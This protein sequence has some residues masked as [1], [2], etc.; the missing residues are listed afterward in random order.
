MI[1]GL[2]GVDHA[3][4]G[5]RDLEGARTAFQ[6]LGFTITPRG[7]HIG[8]GTAN[9]CVMFQEDYLELLGILDSNQFTNNLDRF[10]AK[11]EGLLGLAFASRD[12]T[13]LRESL[14]DQ[15]IP[16]DGPKDLKRILELPGGEAL[17]AFSLLYPSPGTTPGLSAFVCQHLTRDLVWQPHWTKHLNGAVGLHELVTVVDDPGGLALDYARLFG[18]DQVAVSDGLVRVQAG[19]CQLI[20]VLP[21]GLT[22]LYPADLALQKVE[23]PWMAGLTIGVSAIDTTA[24]HLR[25]QGIDLLETRAGRLLVPPEQACGVLLEFVEA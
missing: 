19:A 10:L 24:G 4:V 2:C 20:F 7:R 22:D 8:W 11:R 25:S 21:A 5:V 15:D 23:E 18:E 6:R 14:A 1:P 16:S 9:Y 17:P 12:V 3:L 13:A